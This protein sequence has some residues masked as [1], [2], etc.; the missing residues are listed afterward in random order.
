MANKERTEV[1]FVCGI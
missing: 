1:N